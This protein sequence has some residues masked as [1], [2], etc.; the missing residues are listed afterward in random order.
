MLRNIIKS[1]EDQKVHS[2]R[3]GNG[4]GMKKANT[5]TRYLRRLCAHGAPGKVNRHPSESLT[6]WWM[7]HL[8]PFTFS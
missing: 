4:G 7:K 8:R 2:K 1:H 6:I 3:G 5:E